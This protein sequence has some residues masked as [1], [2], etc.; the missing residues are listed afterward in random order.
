MSNNIEEKC[1][2]C[3]GIYRTFRMF[4]NKYTKE[5]VCEDCLLELDGITTETT[6]H[7]FLDGEYIGNDDEI[8]EVYNNICFYN[9]YEEVKDD[10]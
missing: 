5:L 4:K 7:Y 6:H 9:G 10:E 3:G 8:D 2:I 1:S